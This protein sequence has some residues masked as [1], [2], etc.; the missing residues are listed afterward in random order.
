MLK[1]WRDR[2]FRSRRLA[3]GVAALALVA[4]ACDSGGADDVRSAAGTRPAQAPASTP[5]QGAS[6][7]PEPTGPAQITEADVAALLAEQTQAL[8][9][10]D[11]A[12]FL[13]PYADADPVLAGERRRLFANLRLVPFT[14]AEFTAHKVLETRVAEGA[15]PAQ[16]NVQVRF[17]H[18]ITGVDRAP[19]VAL[20]RY[21]FTR[22]AAGAPLRIETVTGYKGVG[23]P[24]AWDLGDITVVDRPHVVLLAAKADQASAAGWAD[25]METTAAATL[26]AWKGPVGPTNRFLVFAAPDRDH[27]SR[28]YQFEETSATSE[29]ITICRSTPAEDGHPNV[30]AMQGTPGTPRI[31]ALSRSGAFAPKRSTDDS[32]WVRG[33]FADAL[34]S[35]QCE[36][37]CNNRVWASRGFVYTQ[38][39]GYTEA[40]STYRNAAY[41]VAK[42]GGFNG[43]LPGTEAIWSLQGAESDANRYAASLVVHYMALTFGPEKTHQFVA[44]MLRGDDDSAVDQAL[45]EAIG[46]DKATFEKQWAAWVRA[47]A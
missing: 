42:A 20:Y 24:A 21:R 3:G 16:A 31:V 7:A 33:A 22:P 41:W 19:A 29:P 45:K 35:V 36:G 27:Y 17:R 34:M 14:V 1:E 6:A 30:C 26:A 18:Q 40:K 38:I 4:A 43:K 10:G 32:M 44:A 9:T 2:G 13:V 12:A 11:E 23:Y 25:E 46:L 15:E 47:A 28:A 39:W 8:K 5:A 37:R